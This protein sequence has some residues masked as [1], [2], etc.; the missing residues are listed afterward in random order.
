VAQAVKM[1]FL[2]KASQH[3]LA[4]RPDQ[5]GAL[6]LN[7]LCQLVSDGLFSR[8]QMC[9]QAPEEERPHRGIGQHR[10]VRFRRRARL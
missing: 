10:H 7:Q 9:F 3:L 2:S 6:L 8:A 5:L 1:S 4:H